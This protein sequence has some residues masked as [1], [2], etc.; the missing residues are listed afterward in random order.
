MDNNLIK[1]SSSSGC[2]SV[3]YID[4]T[5]LSVAFLIADICDVTRESVGHCVGD[6]LLPAVRQTHPVLPPGVAAG[7]LLLL[8]EVLAA[9][10][11]PHLVGE[12]VVGRGL[13]AGGGGEGEGGGEEEGETQ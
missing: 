13:Q 9:E 8:A 1:L 2:H 6:D 11:V 3:K 12:L 5:R 7:P 10:L 4:K